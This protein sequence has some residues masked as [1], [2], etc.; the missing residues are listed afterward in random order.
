[1]DGNGFHANNY[2]NGWSDPDMIL[3]PGTAWFLNNP[4][5]QDASF[6]FVGLV[7]DGTNQLPTGF[8]ACASIIPF[9][10]E[11]LSSSNY[12]F[13]VSNGDQVF[14]FNNSNNTYSAFTF[15]NSSWLPSEPFIGMC[16]SFWMRKNAGVDW[17]QIFT[18]PN[19]IPQD[20]AEPQ[21]VSQAGQVNFFTFN[22]GDSAFGQVMDSDGSL[23]ST[24]GLG[25]LYAATNDIPDL[26]VPLG[27]PVSF[28]TNG[29]GYISSG[30]VSIPCVP[31]GQNVYVQLRA[32]RQ[33]DATT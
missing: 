16:Q 15:T 20:V 13:P 19:G 14:T 22:A 23:L 29:P 2:L 33:S 8:S 3:L 26:F 6:T 21:L 27:S 32:W 18:D 7:A 28:S 5:W 25:Q 9:G 11:G 4:V 31:G 24:N 17:I 1:M 12:M 30:V 10:G